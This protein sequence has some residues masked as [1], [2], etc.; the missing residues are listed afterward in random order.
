MSEGRF[1]TLTPETMTA[2]QKRVAEAIQ[3]G[4]RGAV[5]RGPCNALLRSPELCDLVQ[6]VGAYV[7]FGSSIPPRL[8]EMAIIMAGRKWTAQYEFYAHRRLALEAGLS[9]AIADAIAANPR[10]AS[11]AKDEETVYDFVSHLLASGHVSDAAFLRAQS[12]FGEGGVVDLIGAVGSYSLVSMTLNGARV[13]L[14]DGVTPPL[15]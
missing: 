11:M 6:R 10:P 4:P 12:A 1:T 14:P 7:R 13:P 15:Q 9:P 8:N 2:D 5:L 3:S